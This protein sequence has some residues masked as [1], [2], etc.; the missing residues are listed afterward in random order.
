MNHSFKLRDLFLVAGIVT[1]CCQTASAQLLFSEPFNYTPGSSLANSMNPGGNSWV[2]GSSSEL[3]IGSSQLSYAGLQQAAGNDL[4]Y[5]SSGSASSSINTYTAVTSGNIYYSFVIDCTTLPTA[6]EYVTSL[7]GS[8]A[9]PGGSSDDLA[10]YVG[11][12]GAGSGQWKVGIRTTGGGS[13]ASYVTGLNPNQNY[14][15][16]EELTLGS[17][18]VAN[19]W[20]DPVPGAAQPAAGATQSTAT[21]INSVDDIGYK[22]QSVT[23]TGNFDISSVLIG[24]TWGDVTPASS[25]EPNTLSLVG[26][27]LVVLQMARRRFQK[28]A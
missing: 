11:T 9:A 5:T 19:V 27:G 2:N 13:G 20:V 28:R 10:T 24:E 25:P 14:L 6:N 4:V 26:G 3:Q 15:V 23:S 1:T 8:T 21:A 12:S 17:A 7:N 22:V 18:P 16:V